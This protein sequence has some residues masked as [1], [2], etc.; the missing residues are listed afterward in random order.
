MSSIRA[1]DIPID[2]CYDKCNHWP[3]LQDIPN[4]QRCKYEGHTKKTKY[5][6]LQCKVFLCVQIINHCFTVFHGVEIDG[7]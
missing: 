3:V 1:Q 4:S 5:Q 2:I 7:S 6:C